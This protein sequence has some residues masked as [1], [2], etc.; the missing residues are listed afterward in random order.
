MNRCNMQSQ[1]QTQNHLQAQNNQEISIFDRMGIDHGLAN[2]IRSQISIGAP[3]ETIAL[4]VTRCRQLGVDPLGRMLY[5]IPRN[6]KKQ[7]ERTGK[8]ETTETH[9]IL[10]S[11]ID[12]FRAMAEFHGEYS[13]QIGPFWC[14]K[15]EVWK[16]MW[17]DDK[18]PCAAKVGV[19]RKS[20]KTPL[21]AIAIWKEYAPVDKDGNPTGFWNKMPSLM[22]AKVAEAL[23]L[24]KAFPSKLTGIYTEDEMQQE[25]EIN[26]KQKFSERIDKHDHQKSIKDIPSLEHKVHEDVIPKIEIIETLT[27]EQQANI[28]TLASEISFNIENILNAYSKN[29]DKKIEHLGEIPTNYYP[30]IMK[31]LEDKRKEIES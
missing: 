21:Y 9:W 26:P 23:A 18:P 16:D 7:N 12:L 15:D 5:A 1:L 20:F 4:L 11:S 6:K 28:E 10:Q 13:G 25:K 19:L 17:L 30:V 27:T 3:D 2:L 22:I 24:R 8:W 29:L 31:R 14:G